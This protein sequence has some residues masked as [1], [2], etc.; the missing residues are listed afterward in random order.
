VQTRSKVLARGVDRVAVIFILA[1]KVDLLLTRQTFPS[2]ALVRTTIDVIRTVAPPAA[3]S[4]VAGTVVEAR[5]AGT[6]VDV[7]IASATKPTAAVASILLDVLVPAN[8]VSIAV[9]AGARKLVNR[10]GT[11]GQ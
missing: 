11:V 4:L 7:D 5:L 9:D 2:T 10:N 1:A 6:L 8:A 3:D